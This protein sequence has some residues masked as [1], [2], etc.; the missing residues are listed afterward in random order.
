MQSRVEDANSRAAYRT[1]GAVC[2]VGDDTLI[3]Y[4]KH[5]AIDALPKCAH[6]WRRL[7]SEVLDA[8]N[9]VVLDLPE[10]VPVALA[11]RCLGRAFQKVP[12]VTKGA[13]TKIPTGEILA[14]FGPELT[15]SAVLSVARKIGLVV[16]RKPTR[17][18]GAYV[19]TTLPQSAARAA[20]IAEELGRLPAVEYAEPNWIVI[21]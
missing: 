11:D 21:R 16:K 4:Q 20:R 15:P 14:K 5:G 10:A 8:A 12:L 7:Q 9:I 6:S 2:I 18:N 3:A 19:L 17:M 13:V 1:F